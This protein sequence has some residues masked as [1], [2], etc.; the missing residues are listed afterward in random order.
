MAEDRALDNPVWHALRGPLA[1]FADGQAPARDAVRFAPEVSIFAGVAVTTAFSGALTLHLLSGGLWLGAFFMATDYVTSP[2]TRNGKIVF[3]L[4]IGALTG[5]IRL[6]GGY[7]EG[8]CYAILLA[9]TLVPALNTW[10]RPRRTM[11]AGTPS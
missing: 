1:G 3:G 11:L 9:N 10:F 8:I 7:P 4:I 5:I 6:Y 2:V